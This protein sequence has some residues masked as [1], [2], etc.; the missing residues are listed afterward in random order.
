MIESIIILEGKAKTL[1]SIVE[2]GKNYVSEFITG[3]PVQAERNQ[4]IA[5]LER[6]AEYGPPRNLEKFR[7][8]GDNLFEIKSSQIRIICFF[9]G[10]DIN[11]KNVILTHG[12]KKPKKTVLLRE[13]GK[14]LQI[15]KAY[16]ER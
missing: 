10:N 2:G 9:A 13:K 5:L 4:L 14:A 6:I 3:W 8:L 11:N 1:Y 15:K 16:E 12:F 7:P